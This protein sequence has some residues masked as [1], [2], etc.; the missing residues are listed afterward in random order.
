MTFSHEASKKCV[1]SCPDPLYA[2]NTTRKCVEVCPEVSELYGSNSTNEC[3][4]E[5]PYLSFADETIN[6][7]DF[8]STSEA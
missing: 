8:H 5:C 1:Y 7:P 2:D 6:F 3:V 4:E